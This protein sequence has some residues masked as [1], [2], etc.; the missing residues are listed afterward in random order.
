VVKKGEGPSSSNAIPSIPMKLLQ[1]GVDAL[2]LPS[3]VMPQ[4]QRPPFDVNVAYVEA[5]PPPPPPP[6]PP[7]PPP[8]PPPPLPS[9]P[10]PSPPQP[11]RCCNIWKLLSAIITVTTFIVLLLEQLSVRLFY[12]IGG[13]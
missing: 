3:P 6:S 8:P 12:A 11:P 5:H 1:L 10:Q 2:K 9:P 7:P 13:I 4:A